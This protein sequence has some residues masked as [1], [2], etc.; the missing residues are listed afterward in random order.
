MDFDSQK[1]KALRCKNKHL[2]SYV[3]Q[4]MEFRYFAKK[5][6][7][8]DAKWVPKL[9]HNRALGAHASDFWA[10]GRLFESYDFWWISEWQQK[11]TPKWKIETETRKERLARKGRRQPAE[12]FGVSKRQHEFEVPNIIP[13]SI[14]EQPQTETKASLSCFRCRSAH[15][16]GEGGICW[17]HAG[18][19]GGPYWIQKKK[20]RGRQVLPNRWGR[21][22]HQ[23]SWIRSERWSA[24]DARTRY[25]PIFSQKWNENL[26]EC[27]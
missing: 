7:K 24:G 12:A 15:F 23:Q 26:A 10:F 4:N 6:R 1:W 22:D 11:S 13:K 19:L 20:K 17:I 18:N 5:H 16:E 21:N 14:I 8:W 25:L 2:A 9:I 27:S 3:L